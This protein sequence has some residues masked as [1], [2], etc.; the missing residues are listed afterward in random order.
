VR[1]A[2]V[3]AL[4]VSCQA[5]R[6]P[7][8]PPSLAT[9]QF[10]TDFHTY[11][12]QRVGLLP[13]TGASIS[14]DQSQM[15]QA[16]FMVEL[17]HATDVELVRLE[18]HDLEEVPGSEPYRRGRYLP[19]TILELARRYQLDALLVGTVTHIQAF[20]PQ[21]LSISLDLVSCETGMVLWSSSVNLDA[22][23][24]AVH[25]GLAA[26]AALQRSSTGSR[27]SLQL[28]LISPSRFARFAAYEVARRF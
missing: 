28:T 24:R 17:S 1:L 21:A 26:W 23:D 3:L 9:A 8:A 6:P 14:T 22:G 16:A 27:E 7:I 2:F 20:P 4:L 13:L 25:D 19:R 15:L 12:L 18:A 5:I 10:A 11:R